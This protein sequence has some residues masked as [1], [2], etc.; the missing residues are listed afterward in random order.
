MPKYRVSSEGTEL[1][2]ME[3]IQS[4]A[5]S[6][7]ACYK[8]REETQLTTEQNYNA[9]Y[10]VTRLEVEKLC[11][12]FAVINHRCLR[13]KQKSFY[14]YFQPVRAW[15]TGFPDSIEDNPEEMLRFFKGLVQLVEE[16]HTILNEETNQKLR[17]QLIENAYLKF[18]EP[19]GSA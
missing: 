1:R 10:L 8:D 15:V 2:L 13:K 3:F 17:E 7:D 12:E 11:K 6:M 4:I 5:L 19:A 18:A 14:R 16:A 9:T